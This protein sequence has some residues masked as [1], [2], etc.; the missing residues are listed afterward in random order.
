MAETGFEYLGITIEAVKGTPSAT[1]THFMNMVGMVTP[2]R[3]TYEPDEARGLLAPYVRTKGVRNW[4]E[5]TAQ[6]PIDVDVMPYLLN[7]NVDIVA[8]PSIPGG[9]VNARLWEFIP[10]LDS[11]TLEA[12]TLFFGDPNTKI[13]RSAYGLLQEMRIF[14]DASSMDAPSVSVKGVV[15]TPVQMVVPPALPAQTYSTLFSPLDMLLWM[16]TGATAIGTTAI[17]GRVVSAECVLTT[18]IQPKFVAIGPAAANKTYTRHGRGKKWQCVTRLVFELRDMTQYDLMVAET[19]TKMRVR[20]NGA[21]IEGVLYDYVEVDN[22][23]PLRMVDWG[24]LS[25]TNRTLQLEIR[26]QYDA[27]LTA[28][29]RVAV[30][31]DNVAL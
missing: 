19:V 6:G 15:N 30:Q 4:G 20:F 29:F 8:A 22:Y 23:G 10:D 11:D 5:W 14:G 25:G 16:D 3:A 24:V 26:S 17:T 2:R 21:L 31:N 12:F 27:T 28:G 18:D 9:G 1:P 7:G 13:F